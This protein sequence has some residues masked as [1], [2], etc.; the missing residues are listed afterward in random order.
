MKKKYFFLLI[1]FLFVANFY[2]LIIKYNQKHD[3][4]NNINKIINLPVC[5]NITNKKFVS[6]YDEKI[7]FLNNLG[8]QNL[9][10][11]YFSIK[12]IDNK[13]ASPSIIV[14]NKNWSS[15]K[16]IIETIFKNNDLATLSEEEKIKKLTEY[17]Y[18]N[19]YYLYPG[20]RNPEKLIKPVDLFNLFGYGYCSEFAQ[21]LALLAKQLNLNSRVIFFDK[22]VVTEIYYQNNWHMFDSNRNIFLKKNNGQ[23]ANIKNINN[24][25]NLLEQIKKDGDKKL[26]QEIFTK[27][28]IIEINN[29]EFTSN[30][31]VNEKISYNLKPNEEIRFYYDWQDKWFYRNNNKKQPEYFTN[32]LLITP[33]KRKV[34]NI[35]KEQIVSIQLPYPI[36]ASYIQQ[37]DICKHNQLLFSLNKKDWIDVEKYCQDNSLTLTNIFPLGDKA[38]ITN[39][40]FLKFPRFSSL[41]EIRVYTQFQLAPQSILSLQKGNNIIEFKNN[42]KEK[43]ILDFVYCKKEQNQQ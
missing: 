5:K 10:P 20:Y 8:G 6:N 41:G 32:G 15:E 27:K 4:N 23:I 33:I 2:L 7:E 34:R 22:H 39:Q 18:K 11:F 42:K 9:S 31:P 1:A 37:T 30:N 25:L 14:N 43:T 36:L 38:K 29:P 13:K 19:I 26:Y 17:I 24:N 12:N 35:L 16:T 40:Y 28:N 3:E 21:T